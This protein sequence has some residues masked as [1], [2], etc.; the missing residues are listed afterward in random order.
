MSDRELIA[1]EISL[2]EATMC[3]TIASETIDTITIDANIECTTTAEMAAKENP[4]HDRL[5]LSSAEV[6]KLKQK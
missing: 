1:S 3:V 4:F 2:P 5:Y 6:K